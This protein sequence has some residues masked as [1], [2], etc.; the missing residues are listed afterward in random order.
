[1]NKPLKDQIAARISLAK[2]KKI[3][4]KAEAIAK[5][6]GRHTTPSYTDSGETFY[7]DEWVFEKDGLKITFFRE[8]FGHESVKIEHGN[9]IVFEAADNLDKK[10]IITSYI[11]S[12]AWE[13]KFE[14]LYKPIKTLLQK[15]KREKRENLKKKF[16]I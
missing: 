8:H 10:M 15:E 13:K 1:M 6:Y 11:P 9:K 2:K 7:E 4:E 14:E 3:S 12:P 16:G 5:K